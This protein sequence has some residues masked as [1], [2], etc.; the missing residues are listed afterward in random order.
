M[1]KV[2][3]KI[4]VVGMD[5]VG[6]GAFAGPMMVGMCATRMGVDISMMNDSKKLNKS[7]RESLFDVMKG[8]IEKEDLFFETNEVSNSELDELGISVCL[9]KMTNFLA[10]EFMKKNNLKKEDVFFLLDY[11]LSLNEEFNY[12]SYVKADFFCKVVGASSIYAKVKRDS[13]MKELSLKYPY[14]DWDKNAGYGTKK[15]REMI[16]EK[17]VSEYHRKSFLKNLGV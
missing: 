8:M 14:Y 3:G 11:G 4:I 1:K 17:G 2:D 12:G 16:L 13:I 7:K 6:R 15:H 10:T 5:E 9:K